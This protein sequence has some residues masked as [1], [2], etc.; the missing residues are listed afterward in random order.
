[1]PGADG[2]SLGSDLAL[3]LK[4]SVEVIKAGGG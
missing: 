1:M 3:S 2:D 4:K